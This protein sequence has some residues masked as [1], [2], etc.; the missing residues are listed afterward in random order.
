MVISCLKKDNIWPLIAKGPHS[1]LLTDKDSE[2]LYQFVHEPNIQLCP[3]GNTKKF[4]TYTVG[5]RNCGAANK[6][7][8]TAKEVSEKV[9][10]TKFAYSDENKQNIQRKREETNLERHG[11]KNLFCNVDYMKSVWQDTLGV[12]NPRHREDIKLKACDTN[13]IRYGVDNPAKNEQ[14]KNKT[15]QTCVQRYGCESPIQ[16]A[17]VKA[18]QVESIRAKYGVEN[19]AHCATALAKRAATNLKRFGTVHPWQ[20]SVIQSKIRE[21]RRIPFA[22]QFN[23][24]AQ[25]IHQHKYDYSQFR[26]LSLRP[27]STIICPEHGP[28]EMSAYQHIIQ[29]QGCPSCFPGRRSWM[30][31][32][33][34]N[35]LS[36]P[37]HCR[38]IRLTAPNHKRYYVDALVENTVYEFWGDFWHGNPNV[39]DPQD[40]NPILKKTYGQLYQDTLVK[41]QTLQQMGYQIIDVW[42]SDWLAS[43]K[44]TE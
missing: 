14:I 12:E 16:N 27:K 5:Y 10:A 8:C 2:K 20:S 7:S 44:Q 6:C 39:F 30:E 23:E 33:W 36:I 28:F 9:S 32:S 3:Q 13:I 37:L 29:S 31:I 21:T 35:S 34:L 19:V 24:T 1:L 11:V 15:K 40:I 43:K 38:Q 22:M 41:I 18:K 25:Q 26:Y 42:E 4:V 17:D